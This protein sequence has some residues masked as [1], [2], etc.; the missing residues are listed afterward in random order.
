MIRNH[1]IQYEIQSQNGRETM[2]TKIYPIIFLA[3]VLLIS[4]IHCRKEEEQLQRAEVVYVKTA[5]VEQKEMSQNIHTHGRVSS[6]KEI[7]LSFKINGIIRNIYV[8]EGEAVKKGQLLARLDLSEIESQVEQAR[9]AFE[10]VGRDL[11][12]AEDLHKD[13]AVTLEQLQ[14][15]QTAHQVAKSQLEVAEFNLRYAEIHAPANGR[16]LRRLMEENEMVS[17]GM[18]IFFFASTDRDWIVRAGVSDRDLVRLRLNDSAVLQFDAY[19]G[20]TFHAR[21]SEIAE[22]SDPMTGTYEVELK[23]D[24]MDKKL[25]SGFVA[26]VDI[27]PST[28]EMYSIIPI[29]AMAEADGRQGFVYTVDTST[30]RARRIPMTIGFLFEDNVAVASGLEDISF[31]VTEGA[32]YLVE[33]TQVKIVKPDDNTDRTEDT[34]AESGNSLDITQAK[35]VERDASIDEGWDKVVE[36]E[37]LSEEQN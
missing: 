30:N 31:V 34:F 3:T 15:I 27:S 25:V 21:V 12:R 1:N 19:P 18:P 28:K 23:V 37:K 9:S 32:P 24:A 26:Q 14:N 36:P 29:E 2:N 33:G 22:S 17:A 20:Q 7:K 4:N 6:K 11:K 13:K 35:A 10:K 16:I 8:D 5:P